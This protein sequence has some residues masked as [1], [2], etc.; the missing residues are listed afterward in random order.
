VYRFHQR[1]LQHLQSRHSGDRWVLKTGAHLWG[2]EHLLAT[3][4]DERI[5]F[6]HRD[7]VESMTSYASLTSLVRSMGSDHVDRAEVARDWT[8]RLRRAVDHGLQVRE[9]GDYPEA[10]FLDVHFGDFVKDQFAVVEQIYQAFG[11]PIPAEAA[12][13]MR[14]FIDNNPKGKHGAHDY[15]PEDFGVD[16]T[17]VRQEFASYID[18]FGL[19]AP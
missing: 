11:L 4:P 18:R 17:R 6:T 3:Y 14:A 13:R 8:A 10:I 19:K 9:S 5:V 2:L 7:P 15:R 12:S 16:P 1:Q